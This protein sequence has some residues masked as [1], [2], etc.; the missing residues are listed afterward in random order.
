[1]AKFGACLPMHNLFTEDLKTPNQLLPFRE[2]RLLARNSTPQRFASVQGFLCYRS[3]TSRDTIARF[4]QQYFN[5]TQIQN[6]LSKYK[7]KLFDNYRL[8]R[9]YGNYLCRVLTFSTFLQCC[10]FI[11]YFWLL[12]KVLFHILLL[13]A[14]VCYQNV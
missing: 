3:I 4:E 2:H 6:T 12:Y 13:V 7:H 11:C 14:Q 1:M 10:D 8:Y 5:R 9:L